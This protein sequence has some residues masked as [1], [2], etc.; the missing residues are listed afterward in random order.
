MTEQNDDSELRELFHNCVICINTIYF[1]SENNFVV[2]QKC[3]R[4]TLFL[5]ILNRYFP[6]TTHHSQTVPRIVPSS[7][8]CDMCVQ[9]L[10]QSFLAHEE[11]QLDC[12]AME[13]PDDW[14]HCLD[15]QDDHYRFCTFCYQ[16]IVT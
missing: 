14:P 16:M 11:Y 5:T 1:M 10:R 7:H 6:M 15:Q 2:H 13:L 9:K 4:C 12:R 3:N 8:D